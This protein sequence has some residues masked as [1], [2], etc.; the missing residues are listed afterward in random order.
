MALLDVS[1]VSVALPTMQ[2]TLGTTFSGLQWIIDGYTVALTA[3]ILSGGTL[4]D[5][6]GRKLVYLCGL[7]LF[8]IASVGCALARTLELPVTARI[9][10]GFAASAV[11]PGAVALLAHAF[12]EPAERARVM[13]L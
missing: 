3:V 2:R 13:G 4:G 7:T 12:P 5:R 8:T 6:Y 1:V 9:I 11:I 10:Q